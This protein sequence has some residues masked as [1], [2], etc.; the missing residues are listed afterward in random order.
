MQSEIQYG[1]T[2]RDQMYPSKSQYNE[3]IV[4]IKNTY[5]EA[6]NKIMLKQ[7]KLQLPENRKRLLYV[8]TERTIP[9]LHFKKNMLFLKLK[10]ETKYVFKTL[11]VEH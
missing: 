7:N 1:P 10:L 3:T 11:V 5:L 4:L 9:S 2:K 6:V 8:L